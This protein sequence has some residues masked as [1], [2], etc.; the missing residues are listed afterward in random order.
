MSASWVVVHV[1]FRQVRPVHR[2][3]TA[4]QDAAPTVEP[5]GRR[6]PSCAFA[7]GLIEAAKSAARVNTG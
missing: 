6:Q 7:S 4:P 1:Q 2:A 3:L 5:V